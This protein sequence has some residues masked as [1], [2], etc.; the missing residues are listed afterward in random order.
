MKYSLLPDFILKKSSKITLAIILI[1]CL[2]SQQIIAQ[3]SAEK[4]QEV[5]RIIQ[6]ESTLKI[7]DSL[8][9]KFNSLFKTELEKVNLLS[10]S[11][12][13]DFYLRG[14]SLADSWTFIKN[15][16]YHI[17]KSGIDLLVKNLVI[18]SALFHKEQDKRDGI[19][20]IINQKTLEYKPDSETSIEESYLGL[21][22]HN[23]LLLLSLIEG[24]LHKTKLENVVERNFVRD[25]LRKII[26]LYTRRTYCAYDYP[27]SKKSIIKFIN[28]RTGNDL[29]IPGQVKIGNYSIL[30]RNYDMAYTGSLLFELGT[31]LLKFKKTPYTSQYQTMFFGLEVHTPYFRDTTIFNSDSSYNTNDYPHAN[32]LFAGRSVYKLHRSGLY[33]D[34]FTFKLGKIGGNAGKVFQETIHFDISQSPPTSGW[35][36]QIAKGGR[37]GVQFEYEGE[38]MLI[39]HTFSKCL[40]LYL[41]SREGINYGSYQTNGYAGLN[42]SNKPFKYTNQQQVCNKERF[43]S[44]KNN[45]YFSTGITYKYNI[46]N[47][48]LEGFGWRYTLPNDAKSTFPDNAKTSIYKLSSDKIIRNIWEFNLN[49]SYTFKSMTLLYNFHS[50]SPEAKFDEKNF[51]KRNGNGERVNLNGWFQ[52][53]EFGIV[54]HS[55]SR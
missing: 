32:F 44:W 17:N 6:K 40:S 30:R 45:L 46:H 1:S 24:Y 21:Q 42:I 35:G 2:F 37:L 3:D 14:R 18:Y 49:I 20:E 22:T 26:E 54:I 38:N 29:F 15:Y 39:G 12:K 52:W 16:N 41:N 7:Q 10:P 43:Y 47:S 48:M 36:A 19:R 4:V 53:G 11:S 50:R 27:S 13:S 51:P 23:S 34:R 25:E 28:V 31:D 55:L 8:R 9:E 5:T 33:R